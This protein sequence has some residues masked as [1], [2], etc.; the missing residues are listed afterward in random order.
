MNAIQRF[1]QLFRKTLLGAI[2]ALLTTDAARATW[3]EQPVAG[4]SETVFP[5][6]G[7]VD[8]NWNIYYCSSASTGKLYAIY[9]PGPGA[10]WTGSPLVTNCSVYSNNIA[11]DPVNHW[12]FYSG[13]DGFIW[14]IYWTG[15]GWASNKVG[16]NVT[17]GRQ[18]CIDTVFQG[19]W[20]VDGVT[21][22]LW[23]LYWGGSAWIET[24]IDGTNA[25]N[26]YGRVCGVDSLWHVAWYLTDD[27]KSLRGTYWNGSAWVNG[28]PIG[29]PLPGTEFY[30]S[31]CCQEG[32]HTPFNWQYDSVTSNSTRG[33]YFY[34]SGS[35]WTPATCFQDGNLPSP[36]GFCVVSP[37]PYSCLFAG[38]SPYRACFTGWNAYARN[39]T[40]CR[41][42]NA[43]MS[44]GLVP[45]ACGQ[46][47]RAIL[48]APN[49]VAGVKMLFS[50]V[51]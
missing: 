22:H 33:G 44:G 14:V 38:F 5:D 48:C 50:D 17:Y 20:Y 46:D 19:L 9:N 13:T 43:G 32:T 34:W 27:R 49:S 35:A 16:S 39:W 30:N 7:A 40:S 10:N 47:G 11:C 1:T 28:A 37:N 21:G 42:D 36:P 6:N 51:P 29:T 24:K 15:S 8:T 25:R 4:V 31:I 45:L 2:L 41:L 3:F 18:L 23:I 12:T 26:R